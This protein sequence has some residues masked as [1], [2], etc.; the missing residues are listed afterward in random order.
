MEVVVVE[1]GVGVLPSGL[2]L[3]QAPWAVCLSLSHS[4]ACKHHGTCVV[5]RVQRQ[6][7][8][9][10]APYMAGSADLPSDLHDLHWTGCL[11]ALAVGGAGEQQSREFA[12]Q[13]EVF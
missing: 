13:S 9:P 11:Q 1:V 3:H 5:M 6:L 2:V 4:S 7:L 10:A 12:Q 8:L